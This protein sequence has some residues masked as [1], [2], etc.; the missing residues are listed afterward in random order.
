[1]L[2]IAKNDRVGS[3]LVRY[4]EVAATSAPLA[5]LKSKS[6]ARDALLLETAS[7][8]VDF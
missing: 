7:G 5:A 1:L 8:I 2:S 6:A 4:F 3:P